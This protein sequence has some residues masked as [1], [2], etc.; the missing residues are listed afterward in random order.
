MG[1]DLLVALGP[2][3]VNGH[4]LFGQNCHR[5]ARACQPLCRTPGAAHALDEQVRTQ[6]LELPQARQT[7]TVLGS[8]PLDCWGYQHGVNEHQLAMGCATLQTRLTGEGPGL[9]GTDLV[10]LALERCRSARQAVDLVTDLVE[11]HGQGRF[12]GCPPEVEG[13]HAL[14]IA[15]PAEAFAVETAGPFWVYQEIRSVR[16][17]SDVGVV[18]QDWD[19]IAHGLA[20]HAIERGWWPGDGSKLDFAA[21][22][23]TNPRGL[24]SGLRR[25]GR[26]T[27]LLEEQNGHIDAP[28]LR[29]HLLGDHYEGT[30]DEI[31]PR[32]AF[33]GPLPLCQHAGGAGQHATAASLLAELRPDRPPLAW[34]AFGP[35]C[36][37]VYFPVFLDGELPEPLR[38]GGVTPS[39]DSAWWRVQHLNTWMGA[40]PERWPR[41]RDGFAH[42]QARFDQEAEEFA[43]EAAALRERGAVDDLRRLAGLLMEH[44]VEQFEN[45]LER[46]FAPALRV[47]AG[48]AAHF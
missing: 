35:P 8:R 43:G 16:A 34:C 26:A 44:Q 14:L 22:V 47:P 28:F 29:R 31:D 6:F 3:T 10:R 48:T 18:H 9:V 32:E 25:W 4:T 45:V 2:A 15:D 19:R 42:L 38:Q 7:F 30:R 13:D 36:V 24:A 5:P 12:S 20:G 23:Q 33:D 27:L 1:S 40:D 37:G 39:R 17:V 21:A 11:R 46:L 41:V